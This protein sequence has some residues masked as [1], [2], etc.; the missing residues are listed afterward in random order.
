MATLKDPKDE[1][2][3][4]LKAVIQE[5]EANQIR[6]IDKGQKVTDE[7]DQFKSDNL[8]L[9]KQGVALQEEKQFAI[10]AVLAQL[11]DHKK[12]LASEKVLRVKLEVRAD[13]LRDVIETILQELRR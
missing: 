5:L 1:E 11:D 13:T 4:R 8:A 6:L 2:I 3:E 9:T 12:W 7:R 10:S